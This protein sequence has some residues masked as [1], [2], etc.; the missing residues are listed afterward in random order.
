LELILAQDPVE[1]AGE[2]H[3]AHEAAIGRMNLNQH[4]VGTRT[5]EGGTRG[6]NLDRDPARLPLIRESLARFCEVTGLAALL[7][8][9]AP[10]PE[11]IRFGRQENEFCRCLWTS[12]E[13]GCVDCHHTQRELFRRLDRKL[14]PQSVCCAGGIIQLAVPVMVE[15]THVATVLGGKVRLQPRH[16]GAVPGAGGAAG[17]AGDAG[18]NARTARGVLS[19]A[20]VDAGEVA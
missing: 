13:G 15:G 20:V 18:G 12:C 11:P 10:P 16:P 2:A 3:E 8:P 14:R 5:T 6:G 17:V 4:R 1:A 7:V 19:F 9:A